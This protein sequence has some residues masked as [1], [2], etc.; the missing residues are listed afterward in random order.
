MNKLNSPDV[1][2]AL[3]TYKRNLLLQK[4]LKFLLQQK[5]SKTFEII[6]V[7]NDYSA[8]ARDAVEHFRIEAQNYNIQLRYFVQPEQGIS[9]ARNL[10]VE[11][12]LGKYLAF[13]DDDEYPTND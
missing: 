2:V 4:N 7:D 1:S 13:I 10:S 6:V 8:S 3:C 11:M 12:S 9:S 5:T